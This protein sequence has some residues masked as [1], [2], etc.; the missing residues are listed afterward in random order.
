MSAM[1]VLLTLGLLPARGNDAVTQLPPLFVREHRG[2]PTWRYAS[3]AGI[4]VLS[5][6][7][8]GTT[9]AYVKA[10]LLRQRELEQLLPARLQLARDVPLTLIL[11]TPAVE[12]TMNEQ[13]VSIMNAGVKGQ[14]SGYVTPW[15]SSSQI[16][17][18]V[19]T[20]PQLT[21]SDSES[22]GMVY[23]LDPALRA[24]PQME[25]AMLPLS[26]GTK[27]DDG[28]GAITFTLGRIG[29]ILEDRIPPLPSWFKTGFL[30]LC[31]QVTWTDSASVKLGSVFWV[32]NRLTKRIEEETKVQRSTSG[33]SPAAGDNYDLSP[34]SAGDAPVLFLPMRRL[35]AGPSGGATPLTPDQYEI[36]NAQVSLFLHWAYADP[37]RREALWNFVD[38]SSR[39][40]VT[41]DLVRQCFGLDS[42]G[43]GR[44][45]AAH[46]PTAVKNSITLIKVNSIRL[47]TFKLQD[48]SAIDIARIQGD[49]G[50]K[51][52]A[53]VKDHNPLQAEPYVAQVG[54]SLLRLYREG[55][56]DPG[57]LAVVG[58]YYSDLQNDAEARAPLEA[59]AR[60]HVGRPAVYVELAKIRYRIALARP[61]GADGKLGPDQV[62]GI[63]EL[64]EEG[65]SYAPAQIE[66]YALALNT[67]DQA[68][69]APSRAD[70]ALLDEG[71]S[72]FPENFDLVSG[73][74]KL[75]AKCGFADEAR[76]L[77]D[78]GLECA[79]PN[80]VDRLTEL[81]AQ[82]E[83][84]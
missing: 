25:G 48:A 69:T 80:S 19:R 77:V 53:Y 27:S 57:L 2:A 52:I 29:S 75:S 31:E 8:D 78:R 43:L 38:R 18:V 24:A 5:R 46:L 62:G 32:S 37:K 63:L 42:A 39:Q 67:W 74:T 76:Q 50:R 56:T 73:A 21:L 22:T 81:R 30:S 16:F 28:Y 79:A 40:A 7:D 34:E 4:E 12:K 15:A 51:E 84:H 61:T 54:S 35:F 13:L 3:V 68:A 72:L 65:R 20:L 45:L 9:I 58:L 59:A 83:G 6:C 41:D 82:L 26:D 70:L 55:E 33:N 1:A 71:V 14:T 49:M 10:F 44:E 64:L 23:T 36:W 66:A 60:A 47:P 11:I 17:R